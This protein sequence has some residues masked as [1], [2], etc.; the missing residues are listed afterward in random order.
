MDKQLTYWWFSRLKTD[1]SGIGWHGPSP[2]AADVGLSWCAI[3][4]PEPDKV[5]RSLEVQAPETAEGIYTLAG[6][7]LADRPH[8]VAPSPV[9]YGGPDN[10]AAATAMAALVEGLA[11]V[12]DGAGSEAFRHPVISPR[13]AATKTSHV[14]ATI[15]YEASQGYVAYDFNLTNPHTITLR[16]T[17]SGSVID[18]R[19]LLPPG[20]VEAR[21]V[22]AGDAAVTFRTE[23]IGDSHY[24]VFSVP[25][26][27]TQPLTISF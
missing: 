13:W 18:C 20:A 9:S 12:K 5:I 7:T 10:W 2:V 11:G 21:S 16:V 22:S 6:L 19:L 8:Y 26:D 27:A 1:S 24:V 3:D 23:S 4:N 17:G 25:A 15:R 14:A